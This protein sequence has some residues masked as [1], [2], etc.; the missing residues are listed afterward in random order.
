MLCY[1]LDGQKGNTMKLFLVKCL[2]DKIGMDKHFP[3]CVEAYSAKEAIKKFTDAL[4]EYAVE[5][6]MPYERGTD[7]IKLCFED[8]DVCFHYYQFTAEELV[9]K[10]DT[11]K[12]VPF[13]DEHNVSQKSY[14][15]LLHSGSSR[16][17]SDEEAIALVCEEFGFDPAKITI[18]HSVGVYEKEIH[19][20]RLRKVGETERKPL[21]DATDWNYIRFN[22][23]NWFYEM[24]N[25]ELQQYYC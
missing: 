19:T 4:E 13:E 14:D 7:D 6:G 24:H 16:E 25:G 10:R 8:G 1:R 3:N 18:I 22:C 21:Y 5:M 15:A 11:E 17:L 9:L 20:R 23:A 2:G 12:W